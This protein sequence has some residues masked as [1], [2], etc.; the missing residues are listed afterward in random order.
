MFHTPEKTKVV[1]SE[2]ELLTARA[3]MS[4]RRVPR[5][6]RDPEISE[7]G[8]FR[9]A[10][11]LWACRRRSCV[12]SIAV[13]QVCEYLYRLNEDI[14]IGGYCE[15]GEVRDSKDSRRKRIRCQS[16]KIYNGEAI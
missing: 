9:K 7:R 3:I 15:E 10:A 13:L 14:D 12:K 16:I 1:E 8:E 11:T 6:P 4:G 5:S 2:I